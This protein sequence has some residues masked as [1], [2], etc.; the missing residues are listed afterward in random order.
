MGKKSA[1]KRRQARQRRKKEKRAAATKAARALASATVRELAGWPLRETWISEGYD[2]ETRGLVQVLVCRAKDGVWASAA[3]LV[4]LDC[5]GVKR[6]AVRRGMRATEHQRAVQ[7]FYQDQPGFQCA[8]ELAVKVIEQGV[9]YAE[10]LGFP[11]T[12]EVLKTLPFLA[13]VDPADCDEEIILGREGKPFFVAG[14]RDDAEA[15]LAHLAERLGEG[16]FHFIAPAY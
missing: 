16:G 13:G 8:P 3:F 2:S 6:A 10:S 12:A 14:P 1:D 9:A 5:L 7:D 15:V 11:P 4:D